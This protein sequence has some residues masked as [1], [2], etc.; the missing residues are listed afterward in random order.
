MYLQ[1]YTTLAG[2]KMLEA[3]A[4]VVMGQKRK[5]VAN[6]DYSRNE[7]HDDVRYGI[8]VDTSVSLYM[9]VLNA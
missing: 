1:Y 8:A 7:V 2:I 6:C 5:R 9:I 3:P 4:I